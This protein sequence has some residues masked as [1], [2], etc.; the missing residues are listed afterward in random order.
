MASLETVVRGAYE[1]GALSSSD[2]GLPLYASRQW[3]RW[4]GTASVVTPSGIVRTPDDEDSIFVFPVSVQLNVTG[5][6][7]CDWRPG[8]VW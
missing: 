6:L 2:A 4:A 8:D 3:L 5:D 1:I 7:A